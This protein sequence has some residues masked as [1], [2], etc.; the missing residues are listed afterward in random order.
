MEWFL[1]HTDQVFRLTGLHLYQSIV[2]LV[3][4]VIIAVPLAA[5]IRSNKRLS[6]AVLAAGSLLYTIPSLALFVTLPAILGTRILDISNIIIA[7]TIYAVALMLRVAVDAFNSVD[8]GVRQAATAMGYRPLRRFLTV[9][10][11]LSVPVLIAGLRVVSV[12][13]ISMV[14]VGALI[15]VENLG[16]FFRDGLRRY[17]ITEIVV[18]IIATLVLAL[19]MDL[20]FVLLQRILTPWLRAG[21]IG[22]KSGGGPDGGK[23]ADRSSTG[24]TGS[25][26]TPLPGSALAT[27]PDAALKGA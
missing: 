11:P 26:G 12:S 2:P 25:D 18:G 16:F 23:P 19:L 17:F 3:L 21:R 1:A 4:G 15:G 5:L 14:S 10:L 9:D 8:D 6:G 7:L 27:A 24:S 13:N 22:S 20:V